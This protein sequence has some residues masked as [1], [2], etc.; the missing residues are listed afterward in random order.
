MFGGAPE[1]HWFELPVRVSDPASLHEACLRTLERADL[2]LE[3]SRFDEGRI[4]SRWDEVLLPFRGV[5]SR[6]GERRRALIEIVKE[7]DE[8]PGARSA[9]GR[10][11]RLVRIR[12]ERERNVE[13]SKP[14]ISA[15]AKWER[16]EDDAALADRL[17]RILESMVSEFGPSEDFYRRMG[18]DPPKRAGAADAS[19]R[20]P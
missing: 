12:V 5:G 13:K 14:A 19:T 17:G 10:A 3:T 1:P 7:E 16:C 11:R 15:H 18:G 9:D 20:R 6:G 8:D 4:V 2:K